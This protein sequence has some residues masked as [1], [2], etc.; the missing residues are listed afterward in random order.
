[1]PRWQATPGAAS[2]LRLFVWNGP[3]DGAEGSTNLTAGPAHFWQ[4]AVGMGLGADEVK[5]G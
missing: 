1:M 4:D 3:Q 2:L 5:P